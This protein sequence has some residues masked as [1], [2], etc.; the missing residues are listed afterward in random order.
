MLGNSAI[1]AHKEAR[2]AAGTDTNSP[3]MQAAIATLSRRGRRDRVLNEDSYPDG[4]NGKL[5]LS[6]FANKRDR[7]FGQA[8][9]DGL[10]KKIE[11]ATTIAQLTGSEAYAQLDDSMQVLERNAIARVEQADGAPLNTREIAGNVV[12]ASGTSK[13]G[14]IV[15]SSAERAERGTKTLLAARDLGPQ[16]AQISGGQKAMLV[17]TQTVPQIAS[18]ASTGRWI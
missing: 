12:I 7:T 5:K 1:D 4:D 8:E 11:A 18:G 6:S 17:Q 2:I 10:R 14:S 16:A 3:E 13:S 15:S 9:L